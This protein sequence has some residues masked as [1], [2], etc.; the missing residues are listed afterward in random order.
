MKSIAWKWGVDVKGIVHHRRNYDE[1]GILRDVSFGQELDGRK[2][3]EILWGVRW[4]V[5]P[6]GIRRGR[7]SKLFQE[8]AIIPEVVYGE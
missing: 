8:E 3:R 1:G 6:E 2:I 5:I 4:R 7:K